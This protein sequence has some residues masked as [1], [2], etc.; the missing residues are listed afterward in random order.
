MGAYDIF[1][2]VHATDHSN[3]PD[4]RPEYIASFQNMANLATAVGVEGNKITIH[5]PIINMTKSDIVKIGLEHGVDYVHTSSC[6]DVNQQGAACG[7]C[8]ACV[9]RL[10]AFKNNKVSDPINYV[11]A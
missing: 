2:G 10:E 3:Y 5:T 1:I 11:K 7:Y 9:V 4:C 8:L 6:Y